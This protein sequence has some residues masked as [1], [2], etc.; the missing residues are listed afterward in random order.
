MSELCSVATQGPAIGED[1]DSTSREGSFPELEK[2]FSFQIKIVLI[3][4]CNFKPRI[5][6]HAHTCVFV[7]LVNHDSGKLLLGCFSFKKNPL[8]LKWND[9]VR[10]LP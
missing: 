5:Q 1:L 6:M 8:Q 4:K 10:K 9:D 7:L 3:I 2:Y